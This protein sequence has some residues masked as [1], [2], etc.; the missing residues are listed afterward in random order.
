MSHPASCSGCGYQPA[1]SASRCDRR[2]LIAVVDELG[3]SALCGS[4]LVMLLARLRSSED[5]TVFVA[6]PT[7][8]AS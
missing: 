4:C 2:L 8:V 6:R 3:K 5:V 7:A 1:P